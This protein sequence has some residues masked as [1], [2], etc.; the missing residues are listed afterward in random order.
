[1]SPAARQGVL[2]RADG[3]VVAVAERSDDGGEAAT[4]REHLR[5]VQELLALRRRAGRVR[6]AAQTKFVAS[7][8]LGDAPWSDLPPATVEATGFQKGVVLLRYKF[9]R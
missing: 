4:V 2:G 7:S 9:G 6:R 5:P 8:K 1:M 3:G